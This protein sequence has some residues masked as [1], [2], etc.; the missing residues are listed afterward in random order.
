MY[1]LTNIKIEPNNVSR[2]IGPVFTGKIAA[3]GGGGIWALKS[4]EK[5]PAVAE[6]LPDVTPT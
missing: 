6:L 1:Y 4:G 3:G 2:N 5:P